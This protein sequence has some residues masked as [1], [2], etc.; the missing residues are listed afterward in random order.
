MCCN[1]RTWYL[2]HTSTGVPRFCGEAVKATI[3]SAEKLETD[4]FLDI[5]TW[6]PTYES[7][8]RSSPHDPG[9]T[10]VS[11]RNMCTS[12]RERQCTWPSR[13]A[14]IR[15]RTHRH[16]GSN[17]H[18]PCEQAP[19]L[20]KHSKPTSSWLSRAF[21]RATCEDHPTRPI[22]VAQTRP[23]PFPFFLNIILFYSF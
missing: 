12:A 5:E 10:W 16:K 3:Y 4:N 17:A 9:T 19:R 20:P 22:Q 11:A 1:A 15:P 8:M 13:L 6:R 18:T 23:G 2:V 21:S 7:D 14:W